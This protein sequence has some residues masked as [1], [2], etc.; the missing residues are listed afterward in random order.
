MAAS[1]ALYISSS[2]GMG[3]AP[4]DLA[5]ARELRK[6]V[7][8]LEVVWLAGQPASD[9]LRDAG[10]RLLPEN[11][12]WRGASA[13]AEKS[14][15]NGQVNLVRYIYSSLVSWARNASLIS[16]VL[17]DGNVDVMIGNECWEVF[18]PLILRVMRP[19]IPFVMI[20]D[21][22]GV[23]SMT[24]NPLEH[25][26]AWFLNA[27]WALDSTVFR[28][29]SHTV[30]F[31]GE[32]EDVPSLRFGPGLPD[33][34]EHALKHY[35]FIGHVIGFTPEQF[36]D[37]KTWRRRLGYGDEPLVICS[38]GGTT[39]GRGLMELCGRAFPILRRGFPDLRMVL[40]CGPRLDPRSLDLPRGVEA[41]GY[42]PRLYEH[43]ACCDAAVV[44]CGA[45][46]TTELAALKKPFVY[47]PIAGH[48]EQQL[49]ADRL[50]RYGA[51]T[52]MSLEDATPEKLAAA[53]EGELARTGFWPD[54]PVDGA[55]QGARHV[56]R[57]LAQRVG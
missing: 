26:G 34:R 2:I 35:H 43:F 44:Q 25:V 23:D 18:I 20:M 15:R 52:G 45:S 9:V 19:R 21:F 56:S 22:V 42:V 32:P 27:L 37:R 5:I 36:A 33:R 29:G 38:V 13:I 30:M 51:G 41:I 47:F 14:L 40:V 39:L 54:L 57:A 46:S 10:E 7:P 48:F 1:R 55:R 28:T 4:K 50:R 17:R 31:I 6:A 8:G 49:V 24:A 53:I 16:H 11:S 12:R 3:H